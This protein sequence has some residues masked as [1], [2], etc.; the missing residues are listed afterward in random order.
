MLC[1]VLHFRL[2]GDLMVLNRALYLA[3][4]LPFF[5][6]VLSSL[7]TILPRPLKVPS[8]MSHA[9]NL[10]D[11]RCAG[12]FVLSCKTIRLHN[13]LKTLEHVRRMHL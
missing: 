4:L 9:I 10:I 5:E 6:K 1:A 11:L 13:T 8:G 12:G 7:R 3:E 2:T